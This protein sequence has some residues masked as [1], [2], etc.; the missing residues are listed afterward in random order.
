MG[1]GD[2]IVTRIA[3]VGATHA[4]GRVMPPSQPRGPAAAR[5]GDI[6]QHSSFLG[7]L[8]GVVVGAL[9]GA[10][11]F[12]A[13]SAVIVGTGGLA[14][15]AVLALGTAGTM[16]LGGFISD[17]SAAVTNMIDSIGPPDGAI[18]QGSPNVII[19]GKPAARTT[20]DLAACS[21]HPP[22]LIAQGSES[23][24][25]NGQPAAR[26][27]DKLACGATIKSGA[28]KVFIGSGQGTYLDIAEEFSGWQRALLIAVEFLVP[29]TRGMGKGLGKLLTQT[30][31]QAVLAGAKQGAKK[32]G[33]ALKGRLICAKTAF[34]THKGVKRFT[35][36][37]KKFFTGDPIDVT[38][39]SLFDQRTE[40]ELGQ[41][42]PLHFTRSWSPGWRGLLG[43]NWLDN[44]SEAVIVTG[45]WVEVLTLEGAS[46]HF[47]LP[48][49]VDHS[50]NPEHP[51]FRLSRQKQGFVLSER[52]NP[53]RK[54]FALRASAEEDGAIGIQ[55][56]RLTEHRDRNGN[57]VRFH[58]DDRH[59]LANV[60]HSDG[61]A[62]RL[63]YREDGRLTDIRRTDNGLDAVMA[64]YDYH[65]D[66]RLA[67]ADSTQHFHLFYEYNDEGLISRWSDGD[68]TAVDYTY[69]T[70][71]RCIHSVGSGG[72]Y[73]V[74]LTYEP[75]I[76][77]STT[78][79]GHT[80]T[81]H[82]TDQQQVTRVETPCGH[83][84]RYKYD[85]WGNLR[86]QILPEGQT[87][88]LDYLADSGLVTAL[89]DATGATWQ[90][91][92]DDTDRLISMTDPLGRVWWQQYDDRGN[93][94]CFIAPD[95]RKTT[96]TRNEFGLVI[97][98]EEEEGH[99][100]TWEYD[101]HHRLSKLFDEENRSLR[102]GYDSHDRLQRLASGG[103]ALWRWE[104]DRH[105]RV[106]LSDRPNNSLERFRHDRHGNLTAWTDAR[107]VSWYIEYGPFD[108]PVARVDGE[109][110]RW[111]YRY[112]PDSLQLLEVVNPQ[113]ESYRYTL[114]AD[115]R[116]VTE[117]DYAGTQW[118]Y[119][120][121]GNGNC[122]E[123]WD[124]LGNITRF[125]YDAASRLTAMHTPEGTTAYQYDRLGRLLAVTAPDSA[126]LTFEYDEQ[127][128]IVKETQPHGDIQ[129]DYPD[130]VSVESTYYPVGGPNWSVTVEANAVGELKQV[131][132]KG[133]HVLRIER[134]EDGHEWHRQSDKGF[135][136][137]QEHSLMGQLT[138]QRAG[139]N[140]EF[141]EAHEVA[142][143]P[144]PTLAGLDRE[145]R[146]DAA[147][148]LVAA[149]DERQWLRYVVN[150]NG[151][152]TS[153]SDGER[154][155]EHYQYDACGYPARRFD[156]V[157]EIEGERLYQKG[158]RLRQV[159][160]HLFEY[161]EAGRMTAMQLWQEGH[162]PQLTQ[163]RWNS[164]NQLIG[165]QTPGGQ[166]WAYRYDAFGRRTEKVCDQSGQRTT[167]LW[168][169]DVPAEIREY[170][171]N[172][173]HCIRHL[174]F[175]GWQLL[176]QQV[177]FFT[178]NPENRCE[179]LAG[180]IQTQYAVCAPTG[181][182]LALFNEAGHRVWRQPPQSLYGLRLGMRGENADFNPGLQYA[183]QWLD[184]ESGLVYNRF[185][186]YSPVAGQY[187]TPDP[188][189]L[190]GGN[191]PYSYVKNPTIWIDPL[192]LQPK[193]RGRIQAQG[194][195]LEE[196]FA[197]A[198]DTPITAKDAL[199]G[200]DSLEASLSNKD[201]KLRKAE[202]DKARK[203]ILSAEK[204]GGVDA[205]V[206]KTFL[207]KGTAHERV[208]IEVTTG[209]AF[210]PDSPTIRKCP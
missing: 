77:R 61:P 210:V 67:E 170:R 32:A 109:G 114:D 208:D 168:D 129:R 159:G 13:A 44:F 175:D 155:R 86:Q 40:F 82:Y 154:L 131:S 165:V 29:P 75:G 178:P 152:V 49:S 81:W 179:L 102:L 26:V 45:D 57:A 15:A 126:P 3:R 43:E 72:F 192:G 199:A 187:L 116:V 138:A 161:D 181:E 146:Y 197:W 200:L 132:L 133:E 176:A 157:N 22:P 156:G 18:S 177:Q 74:Q 144:Q 80:T 190:L 1:L 142:D 118:R 87:L 196:S 51:E 33:H 37:T 8:A 158:H 127:D 115:G 107:G 21:K 103:G 20:V 94:A 99:K 62:L 151:Q 73:P 90:Y 53:V 7:A 139:R 123:K 93:A 24:F 112:D 36:A 148:N 25:I 191:N 34:T 11:V 120:Y 58:Y 41:T 207:V 141:F 164:Q 193:H 149:N 50:I 119:A 78:P 19:E 186:Y 108:L 198:Q 69:D 46:L 10:A 16:A 209:K 5:E 6:I 135:I 63:Y 42:L 76:T 98:A 121:D 28:S 163:F 97:A 150:G 140:T 204:G 100:R 125:E 122:T 39:G 4:V 60:T 171:H 106:A 104:Y 174:V 203:F 111:Q 30:G 70:Q 65:A 56:W 194:S 31:R 145:Y 172:R 52:N 59:Q 2:D 167:Y 153:V 12:A 38:T 91:H 101:A 206:S 84:T 201:R 128:R 83:V 136:L 184:E 162:R 143:I 183:G 27:G 64:H 105:H 68:Q 66:G 188:I 79:Q 182:P 88:T 134:D 173:L 14:T 55:R 113:G 189:G 117:T 47:A 180:K 92:Y 205:Q 48:P 185:R 147:L 95:G 160:Q 124:A 71:G 54:Y 110:H 169:G 202:F 35:Q 96:L 17:V 195:K 137:R 9:I 166:Q 89:T 130:S 85:E 23:V